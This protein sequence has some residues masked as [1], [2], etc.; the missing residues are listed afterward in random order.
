MAK[1]HW[2]SK[3]KTRQEAYKYGYK[4]GLEHTVANTLNKINYPVNY[5]TETLKYLVPASTHK[6]TPDFVFAKKDGG[7]MYVETKGRWTAID[8]KKIKYVLESNPGIDLRIVFQNGNQKLSKT[9][10]TT[11]EAH[12]LKI[13]VKH[14]ATKM[15]PAEWLVK[16]CQIDE[17]PTL[18]K[19]FFSL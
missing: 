14:V 3:S 8:R 1:N 12:A 13:G 11:Y 4:S 17:Q 2:N 10:K 16:C 7:T 15:I 5:E 19:N 6:Y 9:S 18:Q